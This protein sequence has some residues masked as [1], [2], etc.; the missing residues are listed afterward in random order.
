MSQVK[1]SLPLKLG[2]SLIGGATL[3]VCVGAL[4][5]PARAVE[6]CDGD[7]TISDCVTD[8][9]LAAAIAAGLS[10]PDH[11]V[12]A[13]SA[14][15]SDYKD[16][17]DLVVSAPSKGIQDLSGLKTFSRIKT[18]DLSGNPIDNDD[19]QEL[20]GLN[21]L[22]SLDLSNTHVNG[23][24]SQ[25]RPTDKKNLESLHL[26]SDGHFRLSDISAI[27]SFTRLTDLQLKDQKISDVTALKGLSSLNK[28]DL[29]D[30]KIVDVLPLASLT[31]LTDLNITNNRVRDILPLTGL[32]KL[33]P[34]TGLHA[35]GQTITITPR[36]EY[37]KDVDWVLD[38]IR[39]N[40][41]GEVYAD[42]ANDSQMVNND[43][44]LSTTLRNSG[45]IKTASNNS[46]VTWVAP[47]KYRNVE[48]TFSGLVT[49]NSNVQIGTF[50]GT[51]TQYASVVNRLSGNVRY[52]TMGA[53]VEE[54]YPDPEDVDTVIVASGENFPDALAS[55]GLAGKLNAPV[56]LTDSNRLSAR[57][58]GQL[59]RLKPK[60]VI[61][62]GGPSAVSDSVVDQISNRVMAPNEADVIRISGATRRDTAN[63]VFAQASKLHAKGETDKDWTADTAVIATGENFVDALSI[64]SLAKDEQY[65]VFLSGVNGL[66]A[67]TVKAIRNHG[68]TNVIIAG[69]SQAVPQRVVSQLKDA[70]VDGS[71]I[72]RLGGATR[73]QTSLQIA[74]YQ[75]RS[76]GATLENPVFATGENFPDALAGGVLAANKN[77]PIVLVS[78][79]TSVNT[80]ALNWIKS[81]HEFNPDSSYAFVLGG[82]D[83]VS[84]EVSEQISSIL[85]D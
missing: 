59:S 82:V 64:S 14:K 84:E 9:N 5:L 48:Y 51:V 69:G 22:R 11:T 49:T 54:A 31:N 47:A 8:P 26:N 25:L 3:L 41:H 18:L 32:L 12:H 71:N 35:T 77:T 62:V 76:H 81:T 43:A 45:K 6:S 53:I 60:R 67:N 30:N 56:V 4:T 73:Y 72:I 75:Y 66:D 16:T 19:L 85:G 78:P 40:S 68:F 10:D 21:D 37:N 20:A 24:L 50:G 1:K 80:D 79:D 7:S 34:S 46:K 44:G 70:G 28:L 23:N 57:A 42:I 13:N 52:D 27:G 63:E 17:D 65:P 33:N 29:S 15:V 38:G 83:A 58:D 2:A 61:V 74:Q 55:S 39:V 36:H